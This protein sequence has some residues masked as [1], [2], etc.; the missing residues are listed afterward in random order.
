MSGSDSNGDSLTYSLVTNPTYGSVTLSGS[1]VTYTTNSGHVSA[2]TDSFTFKANDGTS[3]SNIGT[4]SIDLK[5]DPLYKYQWHLD[6]TEQSNFAST[7]GT[8]GDDL[9]VDSV[10]NS[11]YTGS[12]VIINVV[13][14][15]LELAHEDLADNIVPGSY[16]LV[17][18]DTDPTNSATS[19]DHGTSVAGISASVG[20]NNLGG[21]GVAPAA[22]LIGYNFLK[23]QS[24][25]NQWNSWGINPPG[26]VQADIYNLSYGYGNSGTY[27]WPYTEAN[28]G[29]SLETALESVTTDQRNNK[30]ALLVKSS[31]NDFNSGSSS[32]TYCGSSGAYPELACTEAIIDTTHQFPYTVVTAAI[33]ADDTKSSYST[34]GPS[35]WISGYGGEY[36]YNSNYV[37]VGSGIYDPAIMTTDQSGCTNGYVGANSAY[38]VNEF[39][40]NSGGY[41]ENA[42]CNY[43]STFNGTSSAAPSVSGVIALMLE[44]NPDLTWRDVKH[45]IASTADKIDENNEFT[46][47]GITQYEWE[48]NAAGFDFH[49][50]Y[51]FGKINAAEAVQEAENYSTDLG[52]FSTTNIN[53]ATTQD[54]TL[55]YG[56]SPHT[57]DIS[58][59]TSSNNNFIEQVQLGFK[60][61]H[62]YP[63]TIGMTL[64]SPSGT[65]VNILQ[66][67]TNVYGNHSG[68]WITVGVN[69]FYGEQ[70][71]GTWTLK[72]TDYLDDSQTGVLQD[73]YLD[74]FFN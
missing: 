60:L 41:S 43:V 21:R 52:T 23:N 33:R 63:D 56:T 10:I 64:V 4:I 8:L 46:L 34:P 54:V 58:S 7:T 14:E 42:D 51:G 35:I 49:N 31:G 73:W 66:P 3:D 71:D 72:I 50:W 19:G 30:G 68:L 15:G 53:W 70:I 5:T 55:P 65:E 27:N 38:Q 74:I 18:N 24:G 69:A 22:S 2:Q 67:F 36:G 57:I 9:N 12:G 13:D 47:A 17:D 39:N 62:I 45:I 32:S 25:S 1:S 61:N 48:T 29:G 26:G 16:D 44:A 6:N 37:S 59:P 11:G 40:N 20:W 28:T